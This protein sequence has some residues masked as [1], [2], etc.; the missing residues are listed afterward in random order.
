MQNEEFLPTGY[1]VPASPSNYMKF[2]E[3]ENTFRVLS[4]AIVGYVYFNKENKPTRSRTT[5]EET[6]DDI[7]KDGKVKPFWA[8]TVWNYETKQIQIL[9][10][11]QKG[12]MQS[13][14]ALVDNKKWGNPKGYDITI[15][16]TGEGLDT[17]YSTMPNPHSEMSD[18][19]KTAFVSK[20]VNLEALYEGKDPFVTE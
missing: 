19:I 1:E 15:T 2:V 16:R 12:I 8:F 4:S 10:V 7:K 11:T 20:P 17:E 5:F 6:P 18:D 14:K 13:I 9:E 3:G